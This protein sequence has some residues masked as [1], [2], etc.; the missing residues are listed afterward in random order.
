MRWSKRKMMSIAATPGPAG[1][2][3]QSAQI[4]S[5]NEF[6][7]PTALAHSLDS[8]LKVKSLAVLPNRSPA[9]TTMEYLAP[10]LGHVSNF[11]GVKRGPLEPI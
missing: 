9:F 6:A 2:D 4:L 11:R 3:R 7:R 10:H 5:T 8:N 1:A